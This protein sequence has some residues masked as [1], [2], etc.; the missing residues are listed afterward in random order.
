MM[1]FLV[2]VLFTFYIQGALKKLKHFGCQKV[3][4]VVGNDVHER[5]YKPETELIYN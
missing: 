2:P 5:L 3:K 4:N 1:P